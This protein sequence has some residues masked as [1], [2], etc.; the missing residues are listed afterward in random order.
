[1]EDSIIP[2]KFAK[3]VRIPVRI[4]KGNVTFF[5]GGSLPVMEDNIIGD[6]IVPAYAIKDPGILK[7]LS[8]E[9]I[10]HVLPLGTIL[11]V[12]FHPKDF[13]NLDANTEHHFRETFRR[14]LQNDSENSFFQI[15]GGYSEVI[16]K[17]PL[18]VFTRGTKFPVWAPC[19]CDIPFL[20]MEA[21]SLNHAYT[22][23][24]QVFEPSR[25]THTGNVFKRVYFQDIDGHWYPLRRISS[26][27]RA[28]EEQDNFIDSKEPNQ[29]L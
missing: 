7:R 15:R 6:L 14:Y 26:R 27:L 29:A 25:M 4:S 19:I 9:T 17:E 13:D 16:L 3:T 22:L 8:K 18:R 10:K 2:D 5:Y 12:E 21:R 24:S 20:N 1:M 28:D 11:L 23:M